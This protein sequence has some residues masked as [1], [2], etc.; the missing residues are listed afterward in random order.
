MIANCITVFLKVQFDSTKLYFSIFLVPFSEG[1]YI[2]F[3]YC[4]HVCLL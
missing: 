1:V 3:F 2:M 4:S